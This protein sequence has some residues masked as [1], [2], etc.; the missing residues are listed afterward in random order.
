MWFSLSDQTVYFLASIA[1][2]AVFGA[3]YDL[4]RGVRLLVRA[5]RIH[6]FISDILFCI[7]CG[8][9]TSLFALPFNKGSVRAFVL[10]GE[11]VGFLGWR[12][13][14]GSVTGKIYAGIA[15][16]LRHFIAKICE[17]IQ[18]FFDLLLKAGALL[19]YNVHE[20]IDKLQEAV[21]IHKRRGSKRSGSSA[22]EPK[23]KVYE[24]KENKK[25]KRR[26]IAR[27]RHR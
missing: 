12:L 7:I 19:V 5:G 15:R 6:I 10:F 3:A 2:G 11:F 1:L 24:R 8:V 18:L 26:G 25:K 16:I 22:V 14:V 20:I 21:L 4:V 9:I 17:K 13:T 27:G 23:G